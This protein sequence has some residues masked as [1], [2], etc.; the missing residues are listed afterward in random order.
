MFGV[1]IIK[2]QP[3][4]GI[5]ENSRNTRGCSARVQRHCAA[6]PYRSGQTKTASNSH[7][8]ELRKAASCYRSRS[9]IQYR[10]STH[11]ARSGNSLQSS[12]YR[13]QSARR[14]ASRQSPSTRKS[15]SS[16][17]YRRI[18]VLRRN[19]YTDFRTVGD[20]KP[21]TSIPMNSRSLLPAGYLA[22]SC[23]EA[24]RECKCAS[25]PGI[26]GEKCLIAFSQTF[27]EHRGRGPK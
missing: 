9:S 3:G 2:I 7:L 17:A 23:V 11:S 10:A 22:I 20:P 1:S 5:L 27:P 16:T 6:R 12:R 4:R 14:E 18:S 8:L 21:S 26:A 24:C 15:V 25:N 19:D 13:Q